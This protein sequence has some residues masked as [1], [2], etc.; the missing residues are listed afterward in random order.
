MKY[1]QVEVIDSQEQFIC[2]LYSPQYLPAKGDTLSL[3]MHQGLKT[4]V[5]GVWLVDGV[6]HTFSDTSQT[7]IVRIKLGA[8]L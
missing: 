7:H 6:R 8:K 3:D 5:L 2:R 4:P 1:I